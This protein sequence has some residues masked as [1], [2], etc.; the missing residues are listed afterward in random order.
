LAEVR[1]EDQGI[2]IRP[3]LTSS[4]ALDLDTRPDVTE[5]LRLS[6]RAAGALALVGL[7]PEAFA[8][9]GAARRD[10]FPGLSSF[11]DNDADAAVFYGVA[12]LPKPLR[13]C[14]GCDL[15]PIANLSLCLGHRARVSLR[16]CARESCPGCGGRR[17]GGC[18]CE[19]SARANEPP[20]S[21]AEALVRT[22]SDFGGQEAAG[23]V[24]DRL[25]DAWITARQTHGPGFNASRMQSLVSALESEGEALRKA[26][27]RPNST[28][29]VSVDQAEEIVHAGEDMGGSFAGYL[30]ASLMTPSSWHL[31]MTIRTDSFAELQSHERF[32]D[33]SA[34][35]YDLRTLPVYRSENVVVQPA[36]RYG[37]DVDPH[38]LDELV[39]DAPKDDALPLLAFALQRMWSQYANTG[40][41]NLASY[42]RIGRLSGL[43]RVAAESAL[44][45]IDPFDEQPLPDR[46]PPR[47]VIAIARRMFVPALAGVNEQGAVVRRVAEWAKFDEDMK[48]LLVSFARWRIVVR[49]G[50]EAGSGT[51]EIAHEALFREWPRLREWLRPDIASL[52]TVR[53][54]SAAADTWE[55]NSR[56]SFLSRRMDKFGRR[57]DWYGKASGLAYV[58]A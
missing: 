54:V 7:N 56:S 46:E 42:N 51:V 12:R 14:G 26:A 27:G 44:R 48:H 16:F 39:N 36:R 21:F 5:H 17:R 8:I 15:G 30:R 37:V 35:I 11:L 47:R 55:R 34:R 19:H 25:Y 52:E 43:I 57:L 18:R 1:A 22:H 49:R 53:S 4:G 40:Q 33:L 32:R 13:R 6:V 3:C 29:L 20:L 9:D 23:R 2:D 24:R 50:A 28:I 38:L 31:A 45:G 58:A 10:P 41:L